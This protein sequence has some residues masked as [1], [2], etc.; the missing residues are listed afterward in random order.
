MTKKKKR[1]AEE[2]VLPGIQERHL[3]EMIFEIVTSS[4]HSFDNKI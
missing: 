4:T 2:E 1:Y 3:R